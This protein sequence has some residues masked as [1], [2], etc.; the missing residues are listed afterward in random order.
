MRMPHLLLVTSLTAALAVGPDDWWSRAKL[1]KPTPPAVGGSWGRT[2]VDAFVLRRLHAAGLEPSPEADRAT[3][4][5]RLTY[6]LHGLPPTPAEIDAFEADR[7]PDAYERVV[8]RLLESPRYGERW[9]RHWLDVVHYGETHGY[10][11]D[12]PRPHAWPYRDWVIRAFN[13]DKPFARFATEQIAGDALFPDEPD[14]IIATGFIAAGPWDFVGHVELREGTVDKKITRSLDRDDMVM[15]VMST[16]T[17]TTAHCARC[18]DH[19]FDPI[20]QEDYYRLQAV[21]AGVDRADRPYEP[22]STA[23]RRRQL[24]RTIADCEKKKTELDASLARLTSPELDATV[25][26]ITELLAECDALAGKPRGSH[27]LGYHSKIM[28]SA[29]TTKWV[30]V[31]L[32]RSVAIDGVLLYPA[33]V[34]YGGHPGPGFGFAPE[35]RVEISD[36]P[37]FANSHTVAVR[38][39]RR[40]PGDTPVAVECAGERA[41]Y[42]RVTATRLWKRTGDWIFALAE[43]VALSD[44]TNVALGRPVTA[45]DS[46]EAGP[47]WALRNLTDGFTSL[48]PLPDDRGL[49]AQWRLASEIAALRARRTRMHRALVPDADKRELA[50]L[51]TRLQRAREELEALPAPELVYA[52]ASRFRPRGN[53]TP[54]VR[55]RKIYV[56]ARGEVQRPG[57]EVTPGALSC[58]PELAAHF[59]PPPVDDRSRRAALARWITD[60]NNPLT[61]RSIVNRVWQ[62]HFGRGIVDTPNDF[63]KMGSLPSHPELLAW[64]AVWFRDSGGSFKKLH[65][66]LVTSA[67]YRQSSANRPPA[68]ARDSGNH[69]LWRMNRRRLEAEAVRDSLLHLSGRIDYTMGG[70]SVR[71]FGFKDDHSPHYDYDKFDADSDCRRSIYRFIVRSVPEP[72]MERLDCPDASISTPVRFTTITAPQALVLLNHRFVVRQCEHFATR[73]EREAD[74]VS[75]RVALA[76]RLALGRHATPEEITVLGAL[77]DEHGLASVCRTLVNLNEFLF[78]D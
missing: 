3:L 26:R 22:A 5:R 73:L 9:A 19:K 14:G 11:K 6:D 71:H 70:P 48:A 54:P 20:P 55:P 59:S 18:H 62:Y 34:V 38:A 65:R 51:A 68:S 39:G 13:E 23:R 50:R 49:V 67:V 75:E 60:P 41:R 44:G 16:F 8:D 37:S 7:S 76:V 33:H 64:L 1:V 17:S 72:F 78:V 42:V 52:A 57:R 21:F 15:N 69:L 40:N 31:D 25:R 2:P 61:W 10:D 43:L 47:S 35:L 32:G 53:F 74:T 66:L 58:L 63:G 24:T 30:Q 56:L 29:R 46:I 77:A 45:M 4:L 28:P 36:D 12:K 27:T